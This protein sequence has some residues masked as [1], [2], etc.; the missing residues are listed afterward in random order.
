MITT[1][2]HSK[3]IRYYSHFLKKDCKKVVNEKDVLEMKINLIKG[4]LNP[5][6]SFCLDFFEKEVF[7]TAIGFKSKEMEMVDNDY[8]KAKEEL[9]LDFKYKMYNSL[10]KKKQSLGY[11]YLIENK[12]TKLTK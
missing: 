8:K 11:V 4:M 10:F 2:S 12:I 5:G 7:K 9:T 1:E 6:F 3:M